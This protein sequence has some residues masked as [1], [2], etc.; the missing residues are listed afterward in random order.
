VAF[1]QQVLGTWAS[2][3]FSSLINVLLLREREK[4]IHKFLCKT[5][6]KKVDYRSFFI[7]IEEK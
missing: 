2:E 3:Y 5:H 7:Y 6:G 1:Q 4:K